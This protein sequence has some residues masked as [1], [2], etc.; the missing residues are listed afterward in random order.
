LF[1]QLAAISLIAL[2]LALVITPWV[3]KLALGW[4][5]LDVP[6]E[7]KVHCQVMPRMGGLAIY[8][9]F[10]AVVLFTQPLAR[11]VMGLL[12]GGGWIMVLGILDDIR[13]LS[14]RVKLVGQIIGAL[15][16]VVFGFRV[17][18]VTNPFME[19]LIL[20]G[21]LAIPVTVLWIIGVTNALNLIDGLDGLAA[22]TSVIAALTM[23]VVVILENPAWGDT[24]STVVPLALILCG[25]ILGFL[26][27]NFYPAKIFLGDSGSMF[28]GFTLAALAIMGLTKGATIIS[29]FIPIVIL[30]IPLLDTV[31][32]IIRRM[33]NGR[34]IFQADKHHLH[35]RLLE[36]GLS[37][38]QAVL[39]I[40]GV[41]VCL[42]LSAIA[43][44]Q[45]STDQGV[46]LLGGLALVVLLAANR[47]GI[48]GQPAGRTVSPPAGGEKSTLHQ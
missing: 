16:L 1:W 39:V 20:L 27:Y 30:G 10:A 21:K 29:V 7:R 15:I 12:L 42:G 43:L 28:L 31:F 14:A 46:I 5:A 33:F 38:R 17:D 35:H 19:G 18:F 34:P 13:E 47:L 24:A 48:T 22:G 45:L 26:R 11:P 40:Y 3:K 25:S 37:H 2:V 41:N 44:T 23:A 6:G 9:A 32:A 36:K 4:G 8:L